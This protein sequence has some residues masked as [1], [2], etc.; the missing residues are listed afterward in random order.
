[1]IKETKHQKKV[2]DAEDPKTNRQ[3]AEEKKEKKAIA[4]EEAQED[5]GT[6]VALGF[7]DGSSIELQSNF[8]K[9][10]AGKLVSYAMKLRRELLNPNLPLKPTYV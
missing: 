1:M 8:K 6:K 3:K 9:M 4:E 7:A 2:D 10:T 5:I